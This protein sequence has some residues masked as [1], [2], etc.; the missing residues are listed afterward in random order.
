MYVIYG[1]VQDVPSHVLIR[2]VLTRRRQIK[3]KNIGLLKYLAVLSKITKKDSEKNVFFI[4]C[5]FIIIDYV[6]L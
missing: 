6:L 3:H 4:L 2:K 1:G 5:C